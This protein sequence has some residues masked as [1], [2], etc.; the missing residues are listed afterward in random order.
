MTINTR[1]AV[2]SGVFDGGGAG[3]LLNVAGGIADF[4][5]ATVQNTG[6]MSVNIGPTGLLLVPAGITP[7]SFAAVTGSGLFHTAG[8][9]LTIPAGQTVNG[10]G[11]INDP[12][13][14]QG[15]ITYPSGYG[16]N[17]ANGLV[18]ASGGTA[19]LGN[20]TLNVNGPN[21]G[22]AG[23]TLSATYEYIGQSGVFTQSAGT[24]TPSGFYLGNLTS[25][26]GT[27]NL[28]GG[29]VSA[30][31]KY[32]GLSG[33]GTFNQSGGTNTITNSYNF[34][35]APAAAREL[36]L[37]RHRHAVG[38]DRE[39]RLQRLGNRQPIGRNRHVLRQPLSWQQLRGR[40]WRLQP[41]RRHAVNAGRV[42]R[43]QRHGRLHANRRDQYRDLR[44]RIGPGQRFRLERRVQSRRRHAR[45]EGPRRRQRKRRLR[46]R[47]RH[48]A[49]DRRFLRLL[50]PGLDR[51]R[52]QRRGRYP[53]L[54]PDPVGHPLRPRR[55]RQAGLGHAQPDRRQ[56]LRRADDDRGRRAAARA[57]RT[58][59][60]LAL[61]GADLQ[62]GQLVFSYTGTSP[63]SFIQS[64]LA[65]SYAGDFA[66]GS[67]LIY[68]S[69]A[70]ANGWALGWAD[71][72]TNAVTVM[73]TLPGD[74]NLDGR[75]DINDLT[76]TLSN[77]GQTGMTWSQ[78]NFTY[79]GRIDINDLTI[80]LT[81]F[82]RSSAAPPSVAGF[83]SVPEP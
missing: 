22:M 82:D 49:S 44:H 10:S 70:A 60:L 53:R 4:S 21:S 63:A 42:R 24:N 43:L 55:H 79:D 54:C 67:A 74:A 61:G 76:I 38:A 72:G 58:R 40:S 1:C 51:N 14:R 68:C 20:G 23:G 46:I 32:I 65:K 48:A 27:Y 28:S 64:I 31:Y 52:R 5:A 80:V 75:M 9:T 66:A 45:A 41:Q 25:D 17:L 15:T 8:T 18:L 29:S 62:G 59:G 71:N 7:A 47:R 73:P 30:A 69:T 34:I 6:G 35:V 78:G 33:T 12:V 13:I 26:A 11:T 83:A 3:G 39:Y 56:H 37:E 19:N 36:Q 16:V 2:V 81:N 77:F 50:A 57:Q